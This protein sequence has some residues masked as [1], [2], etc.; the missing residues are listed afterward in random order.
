MTGYKIPFND[1]Q[2]RYKKI[3]KIINKSLQKVIGDKEFIT[4]KYT[5][6]FEETFSKF[7]KAEDCVGTGSGTLALQV[8]L[9]TL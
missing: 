3:S 2:S 9:K 4:G 1:L 7:V 8:A 6:D 5:K